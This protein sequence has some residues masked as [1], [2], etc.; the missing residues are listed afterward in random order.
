MAPAADDPAMACPYLEYRA[1]AGGQA[2]D[3]ERPFCSVADAFVQPMRADVCAERYGLVPRDHCEIYR[4]HE[5]LS[6]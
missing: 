5:G 4:D 6:E 1:D 3:H 2:F